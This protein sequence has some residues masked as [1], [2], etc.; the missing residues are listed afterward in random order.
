MSEGSDG[1]GSKRAATG[2]VWVNKRDDESH[3]I[4]YLCRVGVRE[5]GQINRERFYASTSTYI[6]LMCDIQHTSRRH[7][8]CLQEFRHAW[9]CHSPEIPDRFPES[10]ERQAM[11]PTTYVFGKSC[12]IIMVALRPTMLSGIAS[13]C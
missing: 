7:R 1:G 6:Y 8:V 3:H 11:H 12:R 5:F 4:P 9:T 10:G 2:G 13:T